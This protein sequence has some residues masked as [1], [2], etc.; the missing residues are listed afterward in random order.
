VIPP[1]TVEAAFSAAARRLARAGIA[2]ARLD[3][4]VLVG[5]AL[6]TGGA[7]VPGRP[8]RGLTADERRR[9]AAL[10]ARRARREP[11]A[12]VVGGREFW[13]L[14]FA[15]TKDVLVPRPDSETVV[16]AALGW[17][18]DRDARLTVLDLGTGSGC[19]VLALLSE[20]P[21]AFGVGVDIS[22][23]A[24]EVARGNARA[25]GLEGR[26]RFVRGDWGAGLRGPFQVIVANPPYIADGDLDALEPEVSAFEPRLAL[27]G[28]ADGL[29]GHRAVAP[30][31][32]GLLAPKGAVFLEIGA[33]QGPAVAAILRRHGMQ[34]VE[35]PCDLAGIPRCL[36]AIPK[37]R[38]KDR[39]K[40]LES[41]AIP[42]TVD[43]R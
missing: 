26:V 28:G 19:L 23:A 4:R 18:G 3:A 13:S 15:V 33:G 35:T 39:K 7:V 29:D 20:L 12:H 9:L 37:T 25:L 30:W 2:G 8:R 41:G 6:G 11:L 43:P 24:L 22:A 21:R 40:G 32:A 31:L 5:H 10:V 27:A 42:A 16:E 14:P 38:R 36:V 17:V 1:H 34:H